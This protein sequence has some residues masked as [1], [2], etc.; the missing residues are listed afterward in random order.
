VP[1]YEYECSRCRCRFE[2]RQRFDEEP[3]DCCPK[4]QG[5]VRRV[6]HSVPVV[7]KG[8]GFYTTD[9]PRNSGT[10]NMTKKEA[11]AEKVE[12]PPQEGAKV[13]S[14]APEGN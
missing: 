11:K 13:E 6:I 9:Y 8:N 10:A 7:F 5:Q 14:T 4:C 1:V 3:I 2:R 12:S